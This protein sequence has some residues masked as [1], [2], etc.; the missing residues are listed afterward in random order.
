[1]IV[2]NLAGHPDPQTPL[3]D[4]LSFTMP[5]GPRAIVQVE[6][7]GTGIHTTFHELNDQTVT[8]WN[9]LQVAQATAQVYFRPES[10]LE[11]FVE[12]TSRPPSPPA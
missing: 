2:H 10:G 4:A 6:Y 8:Y 9:A 1:M 3:F 11:T 12:T 5:M 7:D